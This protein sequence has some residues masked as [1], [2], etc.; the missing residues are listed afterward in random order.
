MLY[1]LSDSQLAIDTLT[2]PFATGFPMLYLRIGSHLEIVTLRTISKT[3]FSMLYLR[4]YFQLSK[5]YVAAITRRAYIA[6][7]VT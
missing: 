4:R 7:E 5:R 6:V 1:L 2:P 3:V